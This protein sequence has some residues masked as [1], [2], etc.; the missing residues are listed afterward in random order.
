MANIEVMAQLSLSK[1]ITN[2]GIMPVL[3]NDSNEK[4]ENSEWRR[5]E[6]GGSKAKY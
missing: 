5:D 1:A 2:G 3:K 6:Q 4:M